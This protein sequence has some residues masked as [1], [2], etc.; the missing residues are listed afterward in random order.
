MID[1]DWQSLVREARA[2]AEEYLLAADETWEAVPSVKLEFRI[3]QGEKYLKAHPKDAK[4]RRFLVDLK[5]ERD[6]LNSDPE[7]QAHR[8]AW[9]EAYSKF[10]GW[11]DYYL[12]LVRRYGEEA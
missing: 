8:A 1:T 2:K 7:E 10:I 5:N 4:A 11:Q 9:N 3:Q 12:E 6:K